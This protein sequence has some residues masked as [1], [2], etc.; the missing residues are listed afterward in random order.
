MARKIEVEIVGD[1]SSLERA[2]RNTGKAGT[3]LGQKLKKVGRAAA[4]GLGVG[5]AAAAVEL[6][7]SVDAAMEAQVAQGRLQAQ[8]KAS[9]ISFDKYSKQI[10]STLQAQAELSAFDDEDL[11]DSF[12]NLVRVTEDVNRALHLNALAADF[13]RAKGID[14]AKAGN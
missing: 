11:S 8:L 4:I 13:A 14:V 9:G 10:D 7:R 12:T 3:T 6:K 1:S 5:V 2:F